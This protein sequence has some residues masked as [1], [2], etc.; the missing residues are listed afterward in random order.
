[1]RSTEKERAREN[2]QVKRDRKK[3]P[4]LPSDP[5]GPKKWTKRPPIPNPRRAKERTTNT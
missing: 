1:M 5:F 4:F 2:K 3:N